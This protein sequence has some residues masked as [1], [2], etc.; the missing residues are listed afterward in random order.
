MQFHRNTL[1][2]LVMAVSPVAFAQEAASTAPAG[3]TSSATTPS[4]PIA[5]VAPAKASAAAA[6]VK[7][8]QSRVEVGD[9]LRRERLLFE[10]SAEYQDAVKAQ[11]A[12]Y[13]AF[14][15]ARNES[16]RSLELEPEYAEA[17]KLRDRLNSQIELERQRPSMSPESIEGLI[18][19]RQRLTQQMSAREAEVLANDTRVTDTKQALTAATEKLDGLKREFDVRVRTGEGLA[20]ARQAFRDAQVQYV[21]SAAYSQ[22]SV[23]AANVVLKYAYY[24]QSLSTYRPYVINSPIYNNY[25]YSSGYTPYSTTPSTGIGYGLMPG[26]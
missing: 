21:S 3:P 23:E 9:Y 5:Q 13:K 6:K 20:A 22:A 18:S 11:A 1:V 15:T 19:Y 10:S 14:D 2:L 4:D 25:P 12:A 26:Q 24:V 7:Y 8:D 16:L 17:R